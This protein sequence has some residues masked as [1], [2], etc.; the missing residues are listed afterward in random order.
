M[1]AIKY[2]QTKKKIDRINITARSDANSQPFFNANR[3]LIIKITDVLVVL[4]DEIVK[5]EERKR[6]A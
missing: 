5:L 2:I 6:N 4:L 3:A 1:N